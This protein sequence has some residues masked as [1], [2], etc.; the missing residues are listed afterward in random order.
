[1]SNKSQ[2]LLNF[3]QVWTY[4]DQFSCIHISKYCIAGL[5][6]PN[7]D[8]FRQ[9][10]PI[11]L[12]VL[13]TYLKSS[14]SKKI[15]QLEHDFP[16]HFSF[17]M[18]RGIWTSLDEFGRV[19]TNFV[20]C[21]KTYLESSSDNGQINSINWNMISRNTLA[22]C[23]TTGIDCN[24]AGNMPGGNSVTMLLNFDLKNSKI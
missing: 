24:V 9:G 21:F 4:L 16:K 22:G 7:L 3:G 18:F 12:Y 11:L 20:I 2:H 6:L 8:E 13:K 1:M 5:F 10:R 23:F 14:S 15:F 19:W 17:D